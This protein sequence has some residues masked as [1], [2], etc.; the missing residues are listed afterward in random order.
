[1][2]PQ[3]EPSQCWP[4]GRT[5]STARAP[6]NRACRR[7]PRSERGLEALTTERTGARRV[8]PHERR[9][10]QIG[11]RTVRVTVVV[12]VGAPA[13]APVI[14]KVTVVRCALSAALI[15]S[16]EPVPVT[17]DGLNVPVTPEGSPLTESVTAPEKSAVRAI[18]IA[19]VPVLPWRTVTEA[20]DADRDSEHAEGG[21]TASVTVAV[22]VSAPLVPVTVRV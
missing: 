8:A 2:V 15:V 13:L 7:R 17:V 21:V 19:Y 14:V 1:M 10:N 9:M 16:V 5:L 12:A 3:V 22:C 4:A 11:Q 20:G 18:V 6:G